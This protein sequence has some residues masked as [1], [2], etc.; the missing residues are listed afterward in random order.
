M[1]ADDHWLALARRELAWRREP[2]TARAGSFDGHGVRWFADGLLN[3]AD[4]CLDRHAARDPHGTALIAVDDDLG[5]VRW[6]W[7]RLQA[8]VDRAAGALHALGVGPGERVGLCLPTIPEAAVAMLA[9]A[10]LGA[11]H[12][13]VFAGFGADALTSRWNDLGCRVVVVADGTRRG[14]RAIPLKSTIDAALDRCP[15]VRQVL[16]VRR[17][18][19]PAWRSRDVDWQAALAAA[20]PRREA[21]AMPGDAPL[22]VLH[23]SG[24]TGKPKPLVHSAVGSLLHA[25]ATLRATIG[26]RA[27]ERYACHADL[28]WITG[29]SYVLYGPLALGAPA[30]L[31]EGTPLHPGPDRLWKLVDRHRLTALFTVPT[32]LRLLAAAGDGHLADSDRSSLRVIACA[33]EVL[34]PA[35]WA[36]AR[37]RVGRER[38]RVVNIYGQTEAAGH[39]LAALPEQAEADVGL[40]PCPG[41]ATELLDAAGTTITG[42]GEGR[43]AISQPWPGMATNLR[44]DGRYITGD[45]ATRDADGIYRIIGRDDDVLSLAGHRLAPAEVESAAR[46]ADGCA[47]ACAAGIPDAVRGAALAVFVVPATDADPSAV[48]EAV[49]TAIRA[50]VG[51]LAT[52]R[53]VVPVE[54]VPRTRSGKPVRRL[55]TALLTDGDPGDL[56]TLADPDLPARLRIAVQVI[57]GPAKTSP[58]R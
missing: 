4:S 30:F 21:A 1:H 47:D 42:S 25:V 3:V 40:R 39:L 44:P 54:A 2:A 10:R 18:I 7:S 16:V 55:L 57:T 28:G 13:L 20:A 33:G 15:L 53:W 35:T 51:A 19:D 6:S 32:A 11:V 22:Y 5:E 56:S 23:T 34:D 27:G 38:L 43:L 9:C 12:G 45:R 41:I 49:R 17:G 37:N 48:T 26:W 36:W 50:R 14:G 58:G 8:E 31:D 46:S 52:P 24:S 29:H